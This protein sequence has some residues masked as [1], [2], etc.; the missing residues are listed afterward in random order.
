VDLNFSKEDE[1]FR[2]EIAAWMADNLT[3][4]FAELR[5]RGGPGDEHSFH[6]LR[7][8]WEKH[9]AASGWT[10]VGWPKDHGGRGLPIEQQVLFFEEYARAG[11]PGRVGH[12]GEGLAGPT[13]SAFGTEA[14]KKRFLPPI[15]AGEELWCQGY[16]E[17]N[18]GSDL[19]N[20][21]TKAHLEKGEW[22]ID[23]QKSWTS[24][25]QYADWCFVLCRTEAGS[26][27]HSGLSYLLVPMKQPGVTVRPILQMTGTSEFN[28]VF[29]DGARTS[30]E[31][32]VGKP[33]EG[34]SVAMGTSA[35]ERGISTLGQQMN[36]RNE[37]DAII[38]IARQNG[39]DRDPMIRRRLVDAWI[40][41]KVMR[42]NALRMLSKPA[43]AELPREA[44]I[45]KISWATWHRDL[46]KLAMDV[47]GPDAEIGEGAPYDLTALQ[48]LFLFVR[49]DT[50]YAGTNQI[51]RNIIAERALG[52][53]K[54]PRGQ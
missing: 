39:R 1:S 30:E 28:E 34:W 25:A 29:F 15:V 38:D 37:L 31:N 32:I 26:K 47:L 27:L 41:L 44:Y 43:A 52:M 54:E 8:A 22:I 13:I 40:G 35:F 24:L 33:G 6:D 50:I 16:S 49:A 23:G 5:G 14:Q 10:C 11:G 19:A 18:A 3:G 7:H 42:A 17:P 45:Y 9:M 12:I 2:A 20:V 48:R 4:R 53:P 36:F 21:H 46:G 51:Q